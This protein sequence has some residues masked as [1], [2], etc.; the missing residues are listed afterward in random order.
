[1][2]LLPDWTLDWHG[3]KVSSQPWKPFIYDAMID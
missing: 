2:T 1:M 3:G